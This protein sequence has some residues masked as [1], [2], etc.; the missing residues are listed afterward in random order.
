MGEGVE[1]SGRE[2]VAKRSSMMQNQTRSSMAPTTDV[3][4]IDRAVEIYDG[5]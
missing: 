1:D 3:V 4:R 5:N 2:E